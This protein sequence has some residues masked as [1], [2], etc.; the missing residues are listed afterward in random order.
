MDAEANS[1]PSYQYG[2]YFPHIGPQTRYPIPPGILNLQG[3][4]TLSVSLWAQTD[5]GAK[6]STLRLISYAKYESGFDFAG[7]DGKQLQ[8]SWTDRSQYA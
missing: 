1:N 6:L 7:I 2:K 5:A 4:N 8:P 3:S